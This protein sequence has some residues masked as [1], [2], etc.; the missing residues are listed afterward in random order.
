MIRYAGG[1]G[2]AIAIR[3][4][5][6]APRRGVDSNQAMILFRWR[7]L[8]LLLAGSVPLR[9][10]PP[11]PF[12][13]VVWEHTQTL[14]E[15]LRWKKAQSD[16]LNAV[17]LRRLDDLSGEQDDSR[18]QAVVGR[19]RE[20]VKA[21]RAP[22]LAQ[23]RGGPAL[24]QQ[25]IVNDMEDRHALETEAA[26]RIA[27]VH[28]DLQSDLAA[29]AEG[30]DVKGDEEGARAV[31]REAVKWDLARVRAEALSLAATRAPATGAVTA[32]EDAGPEGGTS[33]IVPETNE[34]RLLPSAAGPAV[35]SLREPLRLNIAYRHAEPG[36]VVIRARPF[37]REAGVE[38]FSAS[39]TVFG[40][41]EGSIT[42]ELGSRSPAELESVLLQMVSPGDGRVLAEL[43]TR[44]E[45]TWR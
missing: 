34:I 42:L 35:L 45:A 4:F 2:T 7:M 8:M 29:L 20:A 24:L 27:R 10:E 25:A 17:M 28:R 33:A 13:A 44:L 3:R 5:L 38:A 12:N 15:I 6:V 14:R 22:V 1:S 11:A 30:Y 32:G 40:A 23:T 19:V 36:R 26:A 9:A 39:R 43:Q 16:A 21:G 41:G 31:R 37:F 18:E